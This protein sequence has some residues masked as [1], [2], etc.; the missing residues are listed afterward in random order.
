MGD[1]RTLRL[2]SLH[3]MAHAKLV[4]DQTGADVPDV[5]RIEAH[6]LELNDARWH[7]TI[8]VHR[9]DAA[10]NFMFTDDAEPVTDPQF[11]SLVVGSIWHI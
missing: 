2:V 1:V 8:Y 4:D 6:P 11:V 3:G 9:R 5:L 10:G 7:A